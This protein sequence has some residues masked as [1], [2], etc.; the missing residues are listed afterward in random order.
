MTFWKKLQSVLQNTI[1][2]STNPANH[3][4]GNA[5]LQEIAF[6]SAILMVE[7]ARSDFEITDQETH[8]ITHILSQCFDDEEINAEQLVKTATEHIEELTCLHDFTKCLDNALTHEQKER[9][10][11]AFWQVALADGKINVHEEH[12]IKRFGDLLHLPRSFI[13]KYKTLAQN[14]L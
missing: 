9:L 10:I 8:T 13:F 6:A 12:W 1:T 11:K 4:S 14:D 3:S 5:P 2:A 7:I